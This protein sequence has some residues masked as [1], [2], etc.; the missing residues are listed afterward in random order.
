MTTQQLVEL[1]LALPL[2]ERIDLADALWQSIAEGL[3]PVSEEDAIRE[4]VKRCE[5]L[6]S[7]RVMGRTHDQV[8][9]AAQL[10]MLQ[11]L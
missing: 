8:M 5:A 3:P 9:D 11:Q 7:G 6:E 1:A 2:A 4:A 10:Q